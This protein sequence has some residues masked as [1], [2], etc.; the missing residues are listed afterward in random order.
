MVGKCWPPLLHS[1]ECMFYTYHKLFLK[2]CR[3]CWTLFL[4]YSTSLT[5][6]YGRTNGSTLRG[7]GDVPLPVNIL[8]LCHAVC[9]PSLTETKKKHAFSCT[10]WS[11]LM[12]FWGASPFPTPWKIDVLPPPFFQ[13]KKMMSVLPLGRAEI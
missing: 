6:P 10:K 1:F 3:K 5:E 4:H 9:L 7:I 2:M 12:T 11:K 13:K 8:S